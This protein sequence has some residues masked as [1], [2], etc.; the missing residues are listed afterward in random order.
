MSIHDKIVMKL[1][2]ACDDHRR[3]DFIAMN[4]RDVAKFIRENNYLI[5]SCNGTFGAFNTY[6][7]E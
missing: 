5:S 2:W 1:K 4:G 6:S 7:G 3:V